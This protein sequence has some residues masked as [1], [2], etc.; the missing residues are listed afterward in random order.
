MRRRCSANLTF[1]PPRYNIFY[2][3]QRKGNPDAGRLYPCAPPQKR[4]WRSITKIQCPAAF[5]AGANGP[6]SFFCYEV[7]KNAQNATM[8]CRASA[9]VCTR[10]RPAR[11]CAACAP[12]S[13]PA[14]GGDAL[15]FLSHY[16]TDTVVHPFVCAMCEKDSH[17][18]KRAATA[19]WRLHWTPPCTLRIP[20]QALCPSRTSALPTG[21]ELADITA[22]LHTCLAGNLR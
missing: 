4:R 16:A 18:A 20:A 1:S 7:W 13:R 15:G 19:T 3:H 11:S 22:L 9:T 2:A 8:T 10:K 14:P 5:A 17:T 6:D 21:E 12:T